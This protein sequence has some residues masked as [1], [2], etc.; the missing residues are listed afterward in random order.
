M[1]Q[2]LNRETLQRVA[3]KLSELTRDVLFGDIWQRPDLSPRD[4]SLV[5]LATLTALGRSGQI[6]WH[7]DFALS[8]GVERKEM[9][10]LFT[11]LAFYAGWPAAVAALE[12]LPQE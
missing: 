9:V 11:H 6:P 12:C 1:S 10:E 3:P 8:N 4:R 7:I 2:P 5:T